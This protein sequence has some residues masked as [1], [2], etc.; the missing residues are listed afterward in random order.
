MQFVVDT[1]GVHISYKKISL[2]GQ[3]D[4]VTIL[5]I[6]VCLD[7][8]VSARLKQSDNFF[9]R[10]ALSHAGKHDAAF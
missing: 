4:L 7:D 10:Q 8:H 9:Q 2:G 3:V 5:N 1:G 6:P